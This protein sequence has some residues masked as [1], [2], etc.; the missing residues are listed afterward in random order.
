MGS[1]VKLQPAT[2]SKLAAAEKVSGP[3]MTRALNLLLD[4]GYITRE[5]CPNDGRQVLISISE[6]GQEALIHE[7]Q[8]RDAWLDTRLST[9][10]AEERATLRAA[11]ELLDRL[12]E[13][14]V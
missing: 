12:V 1:I 13:D 4:H 3:A 6:H 10:T 5:P 2:P 8:R 11:T 14:E 9:F 7:R